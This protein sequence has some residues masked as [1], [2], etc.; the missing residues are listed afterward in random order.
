MRTPLSH[1]NPHRPYDEVDSVLCSIT[2]SSKLLLGLRLLLLALLLDDQQ[3]LAQ[4]G[5]GH[6]LE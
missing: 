3:P 2:V 6:L 5:E 4:L 1:A